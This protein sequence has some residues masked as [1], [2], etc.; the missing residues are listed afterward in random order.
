[1][2]TITSANSVLILSVTGLYNVPQIIQ[3]Y[4]ADDAFSVQPVARSESVMGVDARKSSG[5]INSLKEL[6]ITIM[7]DSPSLF[8]FE[9]W[10]N[11]EDA[12]GDLF[13]CDGGIRIPSIGRN[14]VLVNGTMQEASI[15]PAAGKRL[16]EM[17]FKLVFEKIIP[18]PI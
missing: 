3:G 7:P 1:M 5:K 10:M 15:V 2:A 6:S 12:T 16:K 18:E 9:A 4:A 14:Y 11:M 17:S 13:R 8:L